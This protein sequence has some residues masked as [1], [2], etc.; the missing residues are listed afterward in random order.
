M[1]VHW[2]DTSF[3][4]TLASL[5]CRLNVRT[6]LLQRTG[7]SHAGS[8]QEAEN[9]GT[10][11]TNMGSEENVVCEVNIGCEANNGCNR[12]QVCSSGRAIAA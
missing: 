5:Q 12:N 4:R 1:H 8:Q 7:S 11:D 10:T 9:D 2:I 6:Y 3:I